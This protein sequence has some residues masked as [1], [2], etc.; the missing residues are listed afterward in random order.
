[1]KD[2]EPFV[3]GPP[4]E[5]RYVFALYVDGFNPYQSKE[6]K[7][8]ATVT[9]IYLVC[10]NLPPHLRY[11][12]E[13]TLL[14][15]IIPGPQKP[16][17]TE[18]NHYLKPLV[19]ELLVFWETGVFYARTAKY[20]CGRL[21]RCILVPLVCDLPAARQTAGFG[22]HSAKFFCS[23]CKLPLAQISNIDPTTWPPRSGQ[24]HK[25]EAEAWKSQTTIAA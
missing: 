6:A 20:E 5:G 14:V 4:G 10:L 19:D 16:S 1:M 23:M 2:G 12:P 3:F 7:Q 17:L 25:A 15:G 11:L 21:V 18:L 8:V 13:N 9:G 22:G 24:D